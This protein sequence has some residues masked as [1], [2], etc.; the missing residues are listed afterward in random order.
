MGRTIS[1]CRSAGFSLI[2]VV[3][4]VAMLSIVGGLG[5]SRLLLA[6]GRP[7]LVDRTA[8]ELVGNLRLAR[9]MAIGHDAHYRVVVGT[10][11]YQIQRLTF[12]SGSNSWISP[13]TDVR[14]VSLPQPL[15]FSGARPTN[16]AV[17]FD[18]R[19][20][21]V[22]PTSAAM[23]NLQDSAVGVARAVQVRLSGQILPPAIGTLY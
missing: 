5:V 6:Y 13:G 15:V 9:T 7:T 2:E 1:A 16:S 17:E 21:M 8:R 19:G 20:L 22:Q 10:S 11:A 14:T 12:D 3:V 23:L 4:V 18:S